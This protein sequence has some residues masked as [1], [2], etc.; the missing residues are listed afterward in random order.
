MPFL[1]TLKGMFAPIAVARH[2]G[3]SYGTFIGQTYVNVFPDR[4]RAMGA[5]IADSLIDPVAFTES[6]EANVAS[7]EADVDQ[8]FEEFQPS[9]SPR[10]ATARARRQ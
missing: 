4:V 1:A 2:R 3:V 6:V 7:A 9:P 8:V 10:P 5:M